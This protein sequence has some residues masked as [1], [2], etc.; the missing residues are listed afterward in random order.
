MGCGCQNQNDQVE[1]FCPDAGA[2]DQVA[3][4]TTKQS[5]GRRTLLKAA[6][7]G[8]TV[9]ALAGREGFSPFSAL[10]ASPC[11]AGDI[12]VSNGV[13]TNEPCTC[14]GTFDAIASFDVR[15]DNN[16][17]RKC[18]TLILGP[19]GTLGGRSFL[20][21]TDPSGVPNGT[22]SNISGHG[23]IQTMYAHIG[24][25]AC[26]FGSE[27]Y[28]DSVVAFQ[29]AQNSQDTACTGP[30]TRFPGGQCRRKTICVT[31]FGVTLEC[32][33]ANCASTGST[34]CTVNCGGTLYMKAVATGA[35]AGGTAGTYTYTLFRDGTQVG[36]P[37]TGATACFSVASPQ[38]GSYTVTAADNLGC[39]RTSTAV[40]VSVASITAGITARASSGCADAG[41]VTFDAST[42]P[43]GT[44]TFR[45]FVDSEGG[46][47]PDGTGSSFT[48]DPVAFG[49]LDGATHFV[50]C[51]A[52]CG[53][54]T[55][56]AKK[57]VSS[58][59]TTTP[60]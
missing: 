59:V 44:C 19:G 36:S 25:L 56:S 5:I 51:I 16:S 54:C 10:A 45:W 40:A 6:G 49:H 30:L 4:V 12:E 23:T 18:I 32:A 41:K 11:T 33:T 31:G 9:A 29:T 1:D 3:E 26:N 37:I 39:S 55:A 53:G 38:A 2:T 46:G 22:N 58:C 60:S 21:T 20:L 35:S 50:K 7:V 27:C 57:N 17:N 13:I 47:T 42:N 15:N 14:S 28:A 8:A 43:A 34:N 24:T 48:Y 52:D